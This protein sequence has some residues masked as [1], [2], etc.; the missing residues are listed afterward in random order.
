MLTIEFSLLH[1]RLQPKLEYLFD[2]WKELGLIRGKGPKWPPS[3]QRDR[4]YQ[5]LKQCWSLFQRW[6][7]KSVFHFISFLLPKD[8]LHHIRKFISGSWFCE[9][10]WVW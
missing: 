1:T 6:E 8:I 5:L 10:E 9:F 2:E 7:L 3:S 4:T